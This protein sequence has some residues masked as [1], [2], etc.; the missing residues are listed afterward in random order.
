MKHG[1]VAD[2]RL[3][4]LAQSDDVD[5]FAEADDLRTALTRTVAAADAAL[6]D[7][8]VEGIDDERAIAGLEADG[9]LPPRPAV[10]QVVDA[11]V[12]NGI[13]AQPGWRYLSEHHARD[14]A[15]IV[16]RLPDVA[17]GVIVYG[18][19]QV[20]A[21]AVDGLA[22]ADPVVVARATVFSDPAPERVVIGPSSA[23]YDSAA[24]AEELDRRRTRAATRGQRLRALTAGRQRDEAL[25]ARLAALLDQVPADGVEGL[26]ARIAAAEAAAARAATDLAELVQ[27]EDELDRRLEDLAAEST[28]RQRDLAGTRDAITAVEAVL[29][30]ERDVAAPARARLEALPSLIAAAGE[31]KR[32]ADRAIAT[33]EA[34]LDALRRSRIELESRQRGLAVDRAPLGPATPSTGPVEACMAA[35][36]VVDA[37]LREQ[38]P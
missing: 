12:G 24:A 22:V 1:L 15:A 6:L 10:E 34:M 17:D 37:A 27:R 36:H 30:D 35:L 18:D 11:L 38:F 29:I 13:G 3:R 7:L 9:I 14:A 8:R 31:A 26:R 21:H 23:R 25:A 32:A 5:P 2:G 20:A 16:A 28:E 4:Q 33:A 19:P